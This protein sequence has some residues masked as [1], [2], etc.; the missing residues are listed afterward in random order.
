MLTIHGKRVIAFDPG[1]MTGIAFLDG[2]GFLY[3]WHEEDLNVW[4]R[5]NET[6]IAKMDAVVYEN[7]IIGANTIKKTQAPWSLKYIGAIE[8][9]CDKYVIPYKAQMPSD[10]KGFVNDARLKRLEWWSSNDHERDATRHLVKYLFDIK[11][12]SPKDLI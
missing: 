8:Y 5:H 6:M 10:A 7:F 4:L 12:I 9:V 3:R 1:K 11:A 2:N